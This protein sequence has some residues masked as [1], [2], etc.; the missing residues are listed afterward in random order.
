MDSIYY[1]STYYNIIIK[2]INVVI[3]VIIIL[4]VPNQLKILILSAGSKHLSFYL[5][6]LKERRQ[7][8]N[9]S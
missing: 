9:L 4:Y 2:H 5:C 7:L 3:F 8:I 6:C 1:L